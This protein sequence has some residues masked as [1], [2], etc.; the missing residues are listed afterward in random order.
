MT[1]HR[2]NRC[3]VLGEDGAGSSWL[4]DVKPM[5]QRDKGCTKVAQLL[6]RASGQVRARGR[7]PLASALPAG[8]PA[9]C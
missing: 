7:L 6:S 9:G 3:A 5:L 2:N 1:L 4:L 8:Q